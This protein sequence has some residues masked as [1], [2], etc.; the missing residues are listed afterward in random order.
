VEHLRNAMGATRCSTWNMNASPLFVWAVSDPSRPSSARRLVF[1][2]YSLIKLIRKC[3][4]ENHLPKY[5]CS[6]WNIHL[7]DH[8]MDG[9]RNFN[10][11]IATVIPL[12]SQ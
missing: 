8:R 12:S 9:N 11:Q 7:G 2:N 3:P 1:A 5:E 4:C 10:L 6:T